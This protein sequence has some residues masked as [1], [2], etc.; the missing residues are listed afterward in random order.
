MLADMVEGRESKQHEFIEN[1]LIYKYNTYE[2]LDLQQVI[3]G[4][5]LDYEGCAFVAFNIMDAKG[6]RVA[7][8]LGCRAYMYC[9]AKYWILNKGPFVPILAV[10]KEI[11]TNGDLQELWHKK[12]IKATSVNEED[13]VRRLWINMP[14]LLSELWAH[15]Y[16]YEC[17]MLLIEKG[18]KVASHDVSKMI[19]NNIDTHV[20]GELLSRKY[21]D[22]NGLHGVYTHLV[23]AVLIN[24]E[25][26]VRLFLDHG[27]NPNATIHGLTAVHWATSQIN[28]YKIYNMLLSYLDK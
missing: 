20:F 18:V 5:K 28:S 17:G 27:A 7:D 19:H 1:D 9:I 24:K 12:I 21:I 11:Q 26:Y 2:G 6:M 3:E 4:F 14:F 23:Q 13:V 15:C 22:P 10:E 16:D 25:T 8:I